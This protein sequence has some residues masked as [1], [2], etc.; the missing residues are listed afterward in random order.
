MTRRSVFTATGAGL[1]AGVA[2]LVATVA[3]AA[4]T[5][6]DLAPDAFLALAEEGGASPAPYAGA[7]PAPRHRLGPQPARVARYLQLTDDQ[8]EGIR[9]LVEEHRASVGPVV[10]RRRGLRDELRA[11]MEQESPD[12]AAVG[13]VVLRLRAQR[14]SLQTSRDGLRERIAGLLNG[15][16]RVRWEHLQELR[17]AGGPRHRARGGAR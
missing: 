1:L 17:E 15:E 4:G 16:Q 2:V 9:R 5:I 7:R 12:A 10:E 8:K 3:P 14:R 6:P 11:L 13:E